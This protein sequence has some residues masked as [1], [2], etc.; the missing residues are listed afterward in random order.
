MDNKGKRLNH[1][2]SS[3]FVIHVVVVATVTLKLGKQMNE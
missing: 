1:R 2:A 3:E